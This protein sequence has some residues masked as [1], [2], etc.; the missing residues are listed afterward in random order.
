[1]KSLVLDRCIHKL[2]STGVL[3][4]FDNNVLLE[5]FCT[6]EEPWQDNAK[7]ISCIPEGNYKGYID[8]E[9]KFRVTNVK[10]RSGIL[11][12]SGLNLGHTEGCILVPDFKN[13]KILFKVGESFSINIRNKLWSM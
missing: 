4:I 12:H 9:G 3:M 10:G 7:W 11:I 8:T 6:I 5:K 13:F 1:M 2:M